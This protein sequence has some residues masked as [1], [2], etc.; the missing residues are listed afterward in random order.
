[1]IGHPSGA[2]AVGLLGRPLQQQ[3][4]THGPFA[5]TF[6]VVRRPGIDVRVG[7]FTGPE[8]KTAHAASSAMR[9]SVALA[10]K[11]A[12]RYENLAKDPNSSIIFAFAGEN[13]SGS[14]VEFSADPT[15]VS[16][17]LGL[18]CQPIR[19]NF[20][21]AWGGFHRHWRVCSLRVS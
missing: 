7:A 5:R 11:R 21:R 3:L 17:D 2:V 19:R 4:H 10:Q 6:L 20:Q 13:F 15:K 14:R 8:K 12:A 18:N 9:R 1:M 16:A